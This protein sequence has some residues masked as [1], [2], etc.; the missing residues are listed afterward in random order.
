MLFAEII[1]VLFVDVIA[2]VNVEHFQMA[3]EDLQIV[4]V[5]SH[6]KGHYLLK[7]D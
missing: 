1:S 4:Q 3:A 7:G 5:F 6:L 2:T